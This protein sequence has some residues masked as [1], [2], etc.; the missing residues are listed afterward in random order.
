MYVLRRTATPRP[1]LSSSKYRFLVGQ[2]LKWTL[3]RPYVP[4]QHGLLN[5]Q[6]F[7][8][9]NMM[10]ISSTL[11][12]LLGFVVHTMWTSLLYLGSGFIPIGYFIYSLERFM[13][14]YLDIYSSIFSL[15]CQFKLLLPALPNYDRCRYYLGSI[16]VSSNHKDVW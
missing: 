7:F 16:Y 15:I 1:F 12:F 8:L 3:Q 9:S 6:L 13:F 10:M 5:M 14:S 2:Q 4:F 11:G